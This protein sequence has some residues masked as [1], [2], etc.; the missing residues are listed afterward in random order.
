MLRATVATDATTV[1]D[2]IVPRIGAAAR[3]ADLTA[4]A[5]VPAVKAAPKKE[6]VRKISVKETAELGRLP[7]KIEM[8]ERERD[9]LYQKLADTNFLRNGQAVA[10]AKARLEALI[11]ETDALMARWAE[12][13]ALVEQ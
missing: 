13:E 8:A 7:E 4:I 6:K 9:E 3:A 12:L 11:A 5:P 10:K 1:T 2:A